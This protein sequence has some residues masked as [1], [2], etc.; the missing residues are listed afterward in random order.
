METTLLTARAAAGD[1]DSFGQ[2][3]DLYFGRVYDLTWRIL[4]DA[5]A[6][7]AITRDVFESARSELRSMVGADFG[8]WVLLAAARAALAR[9]EQPTADA[10]RVLHEEAFGS[11]D[12][13]DPVASTIR[14]SRA[15]TTR[16]PALFGRR[17]RRSVRAITRRSTSSFA[18]SSKRR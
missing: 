12:A 11:F 8:A 18:S 10:P 1:L 9:I 14:N 3:Y 5:D 7:G 17:R 15:A 13:P 2:L 16:L 6:A 4:R